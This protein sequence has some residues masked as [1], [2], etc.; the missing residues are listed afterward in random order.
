MAVT[1]IELDVELLKKEVSDMKEIH[2]RLDTAI[3]KITDVSNCINRMLAVHEEKISQQE[4]VQIRDAQ[5]FAND[6]KELHSRITTSQKE[7]TELMR[8]QHYEF[9]GEIRRL[10]EDVT[11][12]VGTL[13]KWKYI[14]IGGSIVV[15]FALNAYMRYVM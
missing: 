3:T 9:E 12:R 4:E 15:G 11:N 2:G 14:I 1:D 5:T 13:E 10:R 8:K 7:I 6:V